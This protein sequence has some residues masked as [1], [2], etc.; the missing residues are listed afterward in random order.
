[1]ENQKN[2]D[3]QD[4]QLWVFADYV[5][6]CKRVDRITLKS[7]TATI[8]DEFFI[9]EVRKQDLPRWTM[10]KHIKGKQVEVF[11]K[12]K[13]VFKGWIKDSR[14]S[15]AASLKLDLSYWRVPRF[16][17]DPED[18]RQVVDVISENF[19]QLKHIFINLISSDSYPG[20]GW[21]D[22]SAFC[23]ATDILDGSI[24][25]STVDRMF[26]TVKALTPPGCSGTALLRHEFLETLIR[27]ANA[28]YRESG[29]CQTVA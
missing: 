25:S 24:P 15:I 11:D 18:Y 10:D 12:D 4:P 2:C 16:V 27:V 17:K 13:S 3:G 20:I 29:K 19:V 1:M 7:K 5:K 26:L 21:N 8:S 22:F 28:K 9:T 14:S 23:R 6:P